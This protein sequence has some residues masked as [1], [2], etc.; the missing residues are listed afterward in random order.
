MSCSHVC[1]WPKVNNMI[2]QIWSHPLFSVTFFFGRHFRPKTRAF[3][4]L[5]L[6]YFQLN[7]FIHIMSGDVR[8]R[9]F[10][11]MYLLSL[12]V[13]FL[14]LALYSLSPYFCFALRSIFLMHC[15]MDQCSTF[16]C[17][18][19]FVEDKCTQYFALFFCPP[20]FK[21]AALCLSFSSRSFAHNLFSLFLLLYFLPFLFFIHFPSPLPSLCLFPLFTPALLSS[22]LCIFRGHFYVSP[23]FEFVWAI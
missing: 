1:V 6:H 14:L 12:V 19:N 22:S 15:F 5:H 3:Y 16:R 23:A 4:M 7:F 18:T 17:S 8:Q 21:F 10:Y 13:W 11:N 9:L 2:R 20:L